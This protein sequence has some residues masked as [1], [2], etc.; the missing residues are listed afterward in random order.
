MKN[1]KLKKLIITAAVISGLV[2]VLAY[3]ENINIQADKQTFDGKNTVFEGN[4]NAQYVDVTVKSPKMTVDSDE[5][6]KPQNATFLN[7]AHAVKKSGYSQSEVKADVISLSLL[8]NRIKA[9]GN[10]DSVVF[11]NKQ[12]LVHIKADS[13]EFD[14]KRNIIIATNNVNIDYKDIK[15]NS[16][17]ARI[18]VDENGALKKVE[19]IGGVTINQPKSVVNASEVLYNPVTNEIVAYGNATSKTTLEDGTPVNIKAD[20]QQYDNATKTLITSGHVVINYKEYTAVG[21]KATFIPENKSDKPNK[22]V[23]IGRAKIIDGERHVEAD[24]IEITINPK[25]FKAEGN[26]KTRFSQVQNY[27]N[28]KK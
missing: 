5:T 14:I 21:P 16:Q 2:P 19:L 1:S 4:V 27:K 23:F 20:F 26:V 9:D 25:N 17:K 8:K 12:Q 28:V 18:S 22:I 13:Q 3:A 10:S 15:T 24:K 6:G 11:K 7:G